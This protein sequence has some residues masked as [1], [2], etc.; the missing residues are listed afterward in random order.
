MG[1]GSLRSVL[2]GY[3]TKNRDDYPLFNA[4]GIRTKEYDDEIEGSGRTKYYMDLNK[5]NVLSGPYP[6][7]TLLYMHTYLAWPGFSDRGG[8]PDE[9]PEFILY[10]AGKQLYRVEF[11]SDDEAISGLQACLCACFP[12]GR[13]N[14]SEKA[15]LKRL[16]DWD[17]QVER[18]EAEMK[19]V[20]EG[21]FDSG[22]L[23]KLV[24]DAFRELTVKT[25][26]WKSTFDADL[27]DTNVFQSSL[28]NDVIVDL[29]M[30]ELTTKIKGL[31]ISN[32]KFRKDS[33]QVGGGI[34]RGSKRY[35]WGAEEIQQSLARLECLCNDKT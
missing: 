19:T 8:M 27:Q 10:G 12:T 25:S 3:F 1:M 24:V 17:E 2:V 23:N 5:E 26:P 33:A 31:V 35:R 32:V 11:N 6:E 14:A 29:V 30:K 13:S 28:S 20:C 16:G 4:G 21:I 18:Q 22:N 15:R 34:T 7:A 9:P